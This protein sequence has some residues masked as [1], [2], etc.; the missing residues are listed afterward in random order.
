MKRKYKTEKEKE[1]DVAF[2]EL[3]ATGKP[4]VE[5]DLFEK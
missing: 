2:E 5:G 1:K 3:A 4:M